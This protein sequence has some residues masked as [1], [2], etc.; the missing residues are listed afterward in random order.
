MKRVSLFAG[1]MCVAALPLAEQAI[2][3]RR[4]PFRLSRQ[5]SLKQRIAEAL[6]SLRD[7]TLEQA[8]EPVLEFPFFQTVPPL[9]N[10][11]ESPFRNCYAPNS[12]LVLV[13]TN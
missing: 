2:R 10:G 6:V 12:H 1:C 4:L 8:L 11:R 5:R 9:A 7:A 3:V 13:Y